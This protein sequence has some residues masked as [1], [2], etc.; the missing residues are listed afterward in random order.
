M[1]RIITGS[2]LIAIGVYVL[3]NGA[4][5]LFCFLSI[6]GC[7]GFYEV[8]KMTELSSLPLMVIN[9][10]MYEA[11]MIGLY[12]NKLPVLFDSVF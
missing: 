2:I 11:L 4:F 9:M 6:I 7:L 8:R 5:P 3:K 1:S 10:L 12:L